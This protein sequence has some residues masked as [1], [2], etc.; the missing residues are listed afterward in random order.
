MTNKGLSNAMTERLELIRRAR[1]SVQYVEFA[2]VESW[3]HA[4]S[5]YF[6]SLN[7]GKVSSTKTLWKGFEVLYDQH[8]TEIHSEAS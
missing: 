3:I 4:A 1:Y 2:A 7:I 6:P 8:C 5:C